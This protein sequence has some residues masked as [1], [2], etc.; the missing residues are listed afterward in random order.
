MTV[1]PLPPPLL[2]GL[3]GPSGSGK[4][5]WL[6]AVLKRLVEAGVRVAT[7][8][9]CHHDPEIEPDRKDSAKHLVSGAEAVMLLSPGKRAVMTKRRGGSPDEIAAYAASLTGAVDLVLV[10]GAREGRFPKIAV[11]NTER[12]WD[13]AEPFPLIARVGRPGVAAVAEDWTDPDDAVTGIRAW[14]AERRAASGIRGFI[15]A[16]GEGRRLGRV[17]KAHL[18]RDHWTLVDRARALLEV[19]TDECVLSAPASVRL[20]GFDLPVITDAPG[21][22]GPL[23]GVLAGLRACA[24][25]GGLFILG[26]DQVG[27][28]ARAMRSVLAAALSQDGPGAATLLDGAGRS[29]PTIA[30]IAASH[31]DRV[32]GIVAGGERSIA[33]VLQELGAVGVA[34]ERGECDDVDEPGDLERLGVRRRDG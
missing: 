24:S 31:R 14:M 10:E 25:D 13:L 20:E 12:A 30:C 11:C 17:S 33:A 6:C 34:S 16:G 22:E 4:T 23:G 27:C 29:T 1:P 19:V 32:E 9:T 8:K 15:L 18:E 26:V 5:T 21:V 3:Y 7:V 2:L 28:S